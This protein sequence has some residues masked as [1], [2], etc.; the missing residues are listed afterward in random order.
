[1]TQT[2]LPLN[3]K[4]H[5]TLCVKANNTFAQAREQHLIPITVDEVVD[6]A[7]EL[8]IVLVKN[9]SVG[10]F[11]L[12]AMMSLQAGKNLYCG[13]QEYPG[14]Y[15]PRALRIYPL[16]LQGNP[17][18]G[19]MEVCIQSNSPLLTEQS[20]NSNTESTSQ[21]L[22]DNNGN[23]SPYLQQQIKSLMQHAE[24]QEVTEAFINLL[25]EH[26]LLHAQ[27]VSV[28]LGKDNS[29]SFDGI[30]MVDNAKLDALSDQ[31]YLTL[32]KSGALQ[33]IY[34]MQHSL[35]QLNRLARLTQQQNVPQQNMPQQQVASG[36]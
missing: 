27:K 17:Q 1:M 30:Y 20:A 4:V 26:E 2:I 25:L 3:D 22:F 16:S 35:K 6:A 10:G 33:V 29:I 32:R 14:I 12:V 18:S 9:S 11:S 21:A 19:Q 23:Q 31:I 24:Q 13:E 5:R 7:T 28:S 36:Q 8:P 15:A 34:A